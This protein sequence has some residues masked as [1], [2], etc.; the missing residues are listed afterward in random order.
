MGHVI[1]GNL[2]LRR[3]LMG[4]LCKETI[5]ENGQEGNVLIGVQT[6]YKVTK[7]LHDKY[8]SDKA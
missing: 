3:L 6:V 5:N 1:T 2:A 4:C 7:R 8:L